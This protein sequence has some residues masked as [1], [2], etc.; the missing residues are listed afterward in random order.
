MASA[1]GMYFFARTHGAV[2]FREGWGRKIMPPE[3]IAALQEAS[4]RHGVVGIFVSRFLPGLRAAV[5][6]FAGVVGM[7]PGRVLVP[8]GLASAIWYAFL[9]AAGSM[10]GRNWEAVKAVVGDA[11]RVLAI[12]AFVATAALVFW[13]WRRARSAKAD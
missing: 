7:P 8:A 2:F 5:P 9:V 3:A 13:V 11:N 4:D 1:A 12:V 10:L 6:P